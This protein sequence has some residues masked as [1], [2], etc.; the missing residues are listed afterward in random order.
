Y[1][2]T[3]LAQ[4]DV[5]R[6]ALRTLDAPGVEP[7]AVA[8]PLLLNELETADTRCVLVFD[9][10]HVIE[11]ARIHEWLEFLLTYLPPAL[12]VILASRADPPLPL[13][14]LRARRE[15]TE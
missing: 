4:H 11:D 13:A 8:L 3:A 14:R 5:G 10:Y 6:G 9:D 2:L 7:I 12:R 1:V 15:L